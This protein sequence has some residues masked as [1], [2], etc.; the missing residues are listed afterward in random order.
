MMLGIT[1][2]HPSDIDLRDPV[3]D[4]F[5]NYFRDIARKNMLIF[6]EVFATIPTDRVRN[7]SQVGP[8]TEG[9]KLKDTDPPTVIDE[10]IIEE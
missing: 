9:K 7:F 4:Q 8:Y 3:S 10:Y 6:E 5:Y 2:D 1:P